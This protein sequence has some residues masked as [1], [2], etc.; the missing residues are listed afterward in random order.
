[1]SHLWTIGLLDVTS[2]ASRTR[3]GQCIVFS[4][5]TNVYSICVCGLDGGIFCSNMAINVHVHVQYNLAICGSLNRTE[6]VFRLE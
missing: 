4:T 6:V 2:V 3:S 1:M 5:C